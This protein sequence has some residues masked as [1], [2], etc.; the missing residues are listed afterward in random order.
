MFY[1]IQRDNIRTY[2]HDFDQAKLEYYKKNGYEF[3]EEDDD[4]NET[5]IDISD[6][7]VEK[8]RKTGTLYFAP[9]EY[10]NERF[11]AV[12]ESLEAMEP[13]FESD[14]MKK[15]FDDDRRQ[16]FSN[17]MTKMRGFKEKEFVRD[18]TKNAQH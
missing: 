10:V 1:A 14:S 5:I 18:E 17:A 7:D 16:K 15:I 13:L 3:I 2:I 12:L 4:G 9:P 6:I 8:T 11:D